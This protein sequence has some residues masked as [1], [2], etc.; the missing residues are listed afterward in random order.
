GRIRAKEISTG[1]TGFGLRIME[2]YFKLFNEYNTS[3]IQHTIIDL[4]D[5]QNHP[6][7]TQVR[8]TIPLNFSYKFSEH[9][10]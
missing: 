6:A 9:G 3:K 8:I 2:D 10:K 1:S 7:G 4:V 5:D